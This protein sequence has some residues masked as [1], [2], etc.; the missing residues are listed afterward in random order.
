MRPRYIFLILALLICIASIAFIMVKGK[1]QDMVNLNS[2]AEIGEGL[3]HSAHRVGGMLTAVSDKEEMEIGDGIDKQINNSFVNKELDNSELG[4]Y[5]TEV[6]NRLTE[7]VK[8]KDMKYK[9]HILETW[10]PTAHA[11]PGGHIYITTGLLMVL[12]SESELAAVLGHEIAHVDAKH[13]IG[14]IQYKVKAGKITGSGI[15]ALADI[16]FGMLFRPGYSEAQETEA[17][18]ASVYLLYKAGYHPAA[19]KYALERIDKYESS[20]EYKNKSATPVGDTLKAVGGLV[21]RYFLSH[22]A[23]RDRF[24]KVD[25]YIAENNLITPDSRFYIGQKNY[26]KNISY[27]KKRFPDEFKKDYVIVEPEK[28]EE[29][30]EEKKAETPPPPSRPEENLLNDVLTGYGVIEKGMTVAD[31][32][33][34]L[35]ASSQAFK[36]EDR[37]GYKNINI[38]NLEDKG[39]SERA[40]LWIE[41]EGGKVKG[42]KIIK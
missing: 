16:G 19:I 29:K 31:V 1:P 9:F 12:R 42:L 3:L 35:P 27:S 8:R 41:L 37:I 10:H 11:A 7:H 20:D 25:K 22:P 30:K 23:A 17:D 24:A 33:K 21:Q 26:E 36:R 39:K 14:I 15:G 40:G 6:G 5:I 18:L 28:K 4:K 38:Y 13:C 34:K 2:V 32:E